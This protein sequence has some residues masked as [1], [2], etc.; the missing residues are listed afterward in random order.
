MDT[1]TFSSARIKFLGEQYEKL[2]YIFNKM[3]DRNKKDSGT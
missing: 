3:V 1:E 2:N